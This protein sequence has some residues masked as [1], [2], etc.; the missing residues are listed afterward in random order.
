MEYVSILK[1]KTIFVAHCPTTQ[2][3]CAAMQTS[4]RRFSRYLGYALILPVVIAMAAV[5]CPEVWAH[6]DDHDHEH[7]TGTHGTETHGEAS[8]NPDSI[9]SAGSQFKGLTGVS[10]R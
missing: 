7:G 4:V 3:S 6:D 10:Q 9:G 2:E 1:L 8:A 5:P